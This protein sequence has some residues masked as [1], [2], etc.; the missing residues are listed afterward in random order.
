VPEAKAKPGHTPGALELSEETRAR[1]AELRAVSEKAEAGDKE[2]RKELRRLVRASSPEVVGRA[3]DI[4]RRAGRVLAHTAAGGDLLTEEALYAKLDTMRVEIAGENPTSLEVLLTERV[5]ACW[6]LVELFDR[7]MAAQLWKETPE[8]KRVPD[9]A[10]RHY[11][12]WQESANARFL[13]AV[14][15]LARVRKLQAGA[16]PVQVNTQVN[17]LQR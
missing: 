17:I 16:P 8:E 3:A 14:R 9:R 6:M 10:L 12:R 11:L 15:E 13:A 7:L 2:A 4:G 5:V 1:L